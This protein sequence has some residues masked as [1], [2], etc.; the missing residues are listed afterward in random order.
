[1]SVDHNIE[2]ITE[3]AELDR[4]ADEWW[5]L[6]QNC[7][8]A[9]PF[10]SPAWLV[11]WIAE[12]AAERFA[13]IAARRM[14]RLTALLPLAMEQEDTRPV[15]ETCGGRITDY[16]GGIFSPG[17]TADCIKGMLSAAKDAASPGM[18]SLSLNRLAEGSPL[19]G[20][21]LPGG[22]KESVRQLTHTCP[23]LPLPANP[24]E[25]AKVLPKRMSSQLRYYRRRADKIGKVTYLCAEPGQELECYER[26]AALHESRWSE[27]GKAGVLFEKNITAFHGAAIPLLADAGLVRLYLLQI[28]GRDAA[29]LY[30]FVT[31]DRFYYYIGG[32]NPDFRSLAAGTLLI[33]HVI[34]R[35]VEMGCTT[36]D[37]LSGSE[38]YKYQ[39]GAKDTAV[40]QRVLDAA[41]K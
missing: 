30:G 2:L 22:W 21:P 18:A 25:L 31:Q 28:D 27:R 16:Q 8:G 12:F 33:G 19:L 29:G 38:P 41:L 39:W 40:Y 6:W 15:A 35:A 37:F 7:L 10:H 4:L 24:E 14:G 9:S 26:V 5:E 36:F 20:S 32:F 11:P 34:E 23:I 13:V 1:M 17:A 3:K